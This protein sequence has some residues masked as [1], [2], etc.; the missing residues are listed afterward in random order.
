MLLYEGDPPERR[1][2]CCPVAVSIPV[3]VVSW[4]KRAAWRRFSPFS[5]SSTGSC[6]PCCWWTALSLARR[7]QKGILFGWVTSGTEAVWTAPKGLGRQ[8]REMRV[9][10]Q[11]T[12]W[13]YMRATFAVAVTVTSDLWGTRR[14]W[15]RREA[16]V[17]FS[18]RL[19]PRATPWF[20]FPLFSSRRGTSMP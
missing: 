1:L 9:M 2:Y 13:I 14:M 12:P 7:S 10:G 11:I 16:A 17:L 15:R 5:G 19:L 4:Q 8:Y 20:N 3:T 6:T 18:L